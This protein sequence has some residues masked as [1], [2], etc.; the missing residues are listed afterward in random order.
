[1]RCCGGARAGPCWRCCGMEVMAKASRRQGRYLPAVFV[2]QNLH[3]LMK[4]RCV[5]AG[6]RA[7]VMGGGRVRVAHF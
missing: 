7:W 3:P 5:I 4:Q 1:L 6:L 2:D